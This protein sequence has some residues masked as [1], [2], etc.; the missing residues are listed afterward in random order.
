M[1]AVCEELV[2]VEIF[3]NIACYDMFLD[4]AARACNADRPVVAS[5]ELFSLL[6]E[7]SH[8][9]VS[10]SL[11]TVPVSK[12]CWKIVVRNNET[13]VASSFRNLTSNI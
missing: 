6:V 13:S 5:T 7:C 11:G 1:L 9:G 12:L 8:V 3:Q 4:L 10:Q 2:L